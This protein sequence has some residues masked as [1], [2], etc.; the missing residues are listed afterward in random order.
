MASDWADAEFASRTVRKISAVIANVFGAR[1]MIS[2]SEVLY[3]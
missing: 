3:G 1:D 2:Y